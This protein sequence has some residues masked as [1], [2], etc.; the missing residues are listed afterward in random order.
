MQYLGSWGGENTASN[1]YG[2]YEYTG[3]PGE[4][5]TT[6]YSLKQ[7]FRNLNT[8]NLQGEHKFF[9]KEYSPRLSYNVASS[10]SKQDDP[11]LSLCEPY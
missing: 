1:L 4:V 8:F 6:T 9:N 5:Y 7:T 11:R 2:R 3:L 10:R